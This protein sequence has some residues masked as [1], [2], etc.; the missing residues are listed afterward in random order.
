MVAT[1]SMIHPETVGQNVVVIGGGEVG[2]EAGMNL[3]KKG[4]NVTVLEMVDKLAAEST[5]IHYYSMFEE[6]WL[7]LPTF[8][9]HVNATVT[10]IQ[11][12]CVTY[13]DKEGVEHSVPCDTVVVSLGM[14]ALTEEALSFYG[15][16]DRFA[17]IG[18]CQKPATVQ[19]A[20]RSAFAVSHSV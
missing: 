16:A 14:K 10:G 3:A 9:S 7:A 11:D 17:L 13:K 12:D 18:D 20:M 8:H 5:M 6:A 4:R 2:V 15:S 19:Q 1:Q